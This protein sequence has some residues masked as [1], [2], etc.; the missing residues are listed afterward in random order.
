M[1]SSKIRGLEYSDEAHMTNYHCSVCHEQILYHAHMEH[2]NPIG[3]E[4][5]G[6]LQHRRRH[7]FEHPECESM[8]GLLKIGA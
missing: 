7:W 6:I 8:V 4:V 5:Y 2:Y 1:Y 3:W